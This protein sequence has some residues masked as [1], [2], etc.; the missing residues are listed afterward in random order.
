MNNKNKKFIKLA[1]RSHT[2]TDPPS[3]AFRFTFIL[4][5]AMDYV[6]QPHS[7]HPHTRLPIIHKDFPHFYLNRCHFRLHRAFSRNSFFFRVCAYLKNHKNI[8]EKKKKQ[9]TYEGHLHLRFTLYA[10]LLVLLSTHAIAFA[11][12][13][14]CM[15]VCV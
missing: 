5:L 2:Y 8:S 7:S 12:Y 3:S 1:F 10:R 13:F 15:C 6:P 11:I 14:L 9:A 4:F